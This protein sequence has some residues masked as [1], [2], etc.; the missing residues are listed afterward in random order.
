MNALSAA[1]GPTRNGSLRSVSVKRDG[2]IVETVDLYD[3]FLKGD[4]S[5]DIRL[6]P[7]DTIFVPSIGPV[8]GLGG[9]VR[10]PAIYELKTEKSLKDVLALA[11]GIMPT[12]YLQRL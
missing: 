5:R 11:D 8:V 1:G 12:G 3:F 6:Q 10:R 4:K 9:N 2:R 7:G